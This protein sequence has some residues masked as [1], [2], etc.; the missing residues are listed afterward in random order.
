MHGQWGF[1]FSFHAL[2]DTICYSE[3]GIF[4]WVLPDQTLTIWD[5]LVTGPHGRVWNQLIWT[6][7]FATVATWADVTDPI[8]PVKGPL[9]T[10]TTPF[11]L[12]FT[13]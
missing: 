3:D 11:G 6:R 10:P 4:W 5:D 9:G 13:V 8:T 7:T 12:S 1:Y 2:A